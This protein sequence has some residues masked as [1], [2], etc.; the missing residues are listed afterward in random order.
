M[1]TRG[2]WSL[3]IGGLA[4]ATSGRLLGLIEFIVAGLIAVAAVVIAVTVRRT[5]PSQLAVSRHL[6]NSCVEVGQ[7]VQVDL[8]VHNLGR[9]KTPLLRLHDSVSSTR[10]VKL[11]LAPIKRGGSTIAAYRLPTT[12]RGVIRLGPVDIDDLDAAGLARRSRTFRNSTTLLVCPP[13]ESVP[14]LRILS[15]HDPMMGDR[16]RQTLGISDEEFDGLREYQSGDDLRKVHWPSSARYD[17]LLVRQFQPSHH[18][19]I[20]LVIDTRPPGDDNDVLDITTS[21]AASISSSVLSTGD[22]VRIQTTEGR[23]TKVIN[24]APRILEIL[25]FLAVLDSGGP[26]IHVSV[27]APGAR[28]VVISADPTLAGMPEAR[29]GLARRLNASALITVDASGWSPQAGPGALGHGWAHITGPGQI[30]VAW[31]RLWSRRRVV[32]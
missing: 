30:A 26:G 15:G 31:S 14:K 23:S 7:P 22:S 6:S 12:R 3:L 1:P 27:P 20:T 28:V 8:E 13:I 18:G 29:A 25:E 21:I 24:G 9:R 19:R 2:G 4:V 11:S 5:R 32:T 16:Q 10:G 17:D